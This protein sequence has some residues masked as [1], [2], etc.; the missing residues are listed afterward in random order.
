[1]LGLVESVSVLFNSMT[2]S[3]RLTINVV[4][5]MLMCYLVLVC[6][7]MFVGWMYGIVLVYSE[8]VD[9]GMVLLIDVFDRL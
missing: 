6:S 4:A 9:S 7:G 1:M 5:G 8:L 2:L 3:N